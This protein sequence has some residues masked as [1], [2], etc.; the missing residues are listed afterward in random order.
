MVS[1]AC[2]LVFSLSL[3][4]IVSYVLPL[5]VPYAKFEAP[6][7]RTLNPS[8]PLFLLTYLY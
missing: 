8:D 3:R 1:L 5:I 6:L 4:P 2:D 7:L